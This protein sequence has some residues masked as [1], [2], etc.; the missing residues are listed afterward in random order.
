M[1]LWL[2]S[3]GVRVGCQ[4]MVRELGQLAICEVGSEGPLASGVSHMGVCPRQNCFGNFC[5]R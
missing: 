4:G 1:L 2:H 5:L 3:T